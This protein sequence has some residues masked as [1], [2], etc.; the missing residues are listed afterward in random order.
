MFAF[1]CQERETRRMETMRASK[2]EEKEYRDLLETAYG[3]ESA[4][5]LIRLCGTQKR[6]VSALYFVAGNHES[7][8]L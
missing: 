5:E 7:R 6:Y 1:A 8:H 3:A 2:K 4:A